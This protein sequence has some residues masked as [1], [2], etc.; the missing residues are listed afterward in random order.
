M[1]SA[2]MITRD[3]GRWL[4]PVLANL[5]RIADELVVI[6]DEASLDDTLA[7]AQRCADRA[8]CWAVPGGY[9][10]AVRNE[11]AA[12]CRG[13][14]LWMAD[15]DE[16]IPP[17]LVRHIPLLLQCGFP[18]YAFARKHVLGDGKSW[19]MSAPW[20]PDYQTRLRSQESWRRSPWPRLPHNTPD[21]T[22]LLVNVP[23][24]HLKFMLRSPDE[25]QARMTAWGQ[26]WE[27]A[28]NEHYR[29]FSLPEQ[30]AWQTAPMDEEP[31]AELGEMPR[32]E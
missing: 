30:Y 14:W 23:F 6:V 15:D 20:W 1:I 25:R 22:G 18:E 7:V 10:E 21:F 5:R 26:T 13:D 8:E 9:A 27:P 31:P 3:A 12:L 32:G 4:A 29:R 11:A 17:A 24:W 19:M 28:L 2:F 16:L